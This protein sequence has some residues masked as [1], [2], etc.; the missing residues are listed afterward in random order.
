MHPIENPFRAALEKRYAQ[1]GIALEHAA[2]GERNQP[3]GA[4]E[5][6]SQKKLGKRLFPV[7][8]SA[9]ADPGARLSC[10]SEC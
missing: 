2:R 5:R 7:F 1:I 3:R 9:A 10:L 6:P 4:I 8:G